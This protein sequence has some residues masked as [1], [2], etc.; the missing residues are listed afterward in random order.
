[1]IMIKDYVTV[2]GVLYNVNCGSNFIQLWKEFYIIM[3]E[4]SLYI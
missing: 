4:F 2:E 1:M 3:E